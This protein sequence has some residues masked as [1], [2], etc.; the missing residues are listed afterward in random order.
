MIL[1]NDSWWLSLIFTFISYI[2]N[3]SVT[4]KTEEYLRKLLDSEKKN[5]NNKSINNKQTQNGYICFTRDK[6]SIINLKTFN[7]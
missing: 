3:S 6:L 1:I 5:N 4:T 2:S 7:K